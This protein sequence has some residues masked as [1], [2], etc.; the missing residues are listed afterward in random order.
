M[1][2]NTQRVKQAREQQVREEKAAEER[3]KNSK[4]LTKIDENLNELIRVAKIAGNIH[5]LELSQGIKELI[6]KIK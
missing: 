5:T 6:R 3:V 4:V 2:T 1:K